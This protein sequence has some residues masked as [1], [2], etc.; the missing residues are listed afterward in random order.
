MLIKDDSYHMSTKHLDTRFLFIH[1]V[2]ERGQIKILYCPTEDMV[3]SILT[4]P[5]QSGRLRGT[6]QRSAYV[7]RAGVCCNI[8]V[9]ALCREV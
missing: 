1:K 6:H 3:A 9:H 8:K 4:K 5:Y 7:A 2:A